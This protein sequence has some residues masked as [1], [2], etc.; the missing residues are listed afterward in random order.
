MRILIIAVPN[1]AGKTSF[2]G[3]FLPAEAQCP[4][5]V[6]ADNIAA[7]LSPFRPDTVA[8]KAGR[9]MRERI[10]LLSSVMHVSTSPSKPRSPPA[11]T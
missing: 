1:G 3:D 5:F 7:G 8:L 11:V 6:N 4:E 9:L 10:H 2:A